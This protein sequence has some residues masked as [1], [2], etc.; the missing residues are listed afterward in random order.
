MFES[1]T[2]YLKWLL[3]MTTLAL[4]FLYGHKHEKDREP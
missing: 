1:K 2:E 4:H 3:N